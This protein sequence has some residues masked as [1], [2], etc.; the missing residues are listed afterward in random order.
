MS[1]SSSLAISASPE[2]VWDVVT[3]FEAYPEWDSGVIEIEGEATEGGYVRMRT[4]LTPERM[5]RM[6]V[7]EPDRLVLVGGLPLKLFRA[8]RTF[9]I[10]PT[11]KGCRITVTEEISGVLRPFVRVPPNVEAS[12]VLYCSGLQKEVARHRRA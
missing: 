9:E 11:R 5:V 6:R 7:A 12:F 1:A 3:D 10:E 8:E 4:D 2:E